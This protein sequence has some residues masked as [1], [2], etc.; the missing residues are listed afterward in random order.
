MCTPTPGWN[1]W[2]ELRDTSPRAEAQMMMSLF[3]V[4]YVLWLIIEMFETN[5]C[6][7]NKTNE[8]KRKIGKM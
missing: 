4:V 7:T 8:V 1:T 6:L 3:I 2:Q 5:K